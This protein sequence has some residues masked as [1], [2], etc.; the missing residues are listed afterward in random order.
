MSD[1]ETEIPAA[2]TSLKKKEGIFDEG[3]LAAIIGLG[4]VFNFYFHKV[5]PIIGGIISGDLGA[6]RYL[7]RSVNTFFTREQM[8]G[9]LGDAGFADVAAYPQTFG[10]AVAYRGVRV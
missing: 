10:I 4:N 9:A 5:M 2:T 3:F 7:P 6:Y 8:V 1:T